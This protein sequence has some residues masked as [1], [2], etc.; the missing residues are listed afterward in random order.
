MTTD[1]EPAAVRRVLTD[2]SNQIL[3]AVGELHAM[4]EQKRTEQI[5]SPPFHELAR[6]IR[7]KSREI[8]RIASAQE[9]LGDQADRNGESIDDVDDAR[10]NRAG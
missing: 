10:G 6:E 4:E 3:Q 1:E 9:D 2:K 7:E 5:S 8:F